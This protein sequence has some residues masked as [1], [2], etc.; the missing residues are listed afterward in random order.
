MKRPSLLYRSAILCCLLSILCSCAPTDTTTSPPEDEVEY[1]FYPEIDGDWWQIAGNPDLGEY[2]TE[3]QQ[4]VDF[5][6]WQAA[7]GTWQLWSCIRHTNCGGN[8]RLFHGWEG[9]SLTDPDWKPL[10]IMME[11]D[12]TLGERQGGMQA[13]HVIVK[14]SIYHMIY[15]SWDNLCL[16][17]SVDGKNF[18]KVIQDHGGTA[19]FRGPMENTRDAMT[20]QI[21]DLYYTYY[22]GHN[23][24]SSNAN[25]KAAIF[26]RTSPDLMEWSE[27]VL[28][29]GGGSVADFDTWGGGDA[30]CPFVVQLEDQYL[31]FRNQ[32]YGQN[33]I[34]TQYLSGNPLDFGVNNDDKVVGMLEVAAP[35]I[36]LHDGQYYI[37]ALLPG[38]NGIRMAKL[39]F[40]KVPKDQDNQERLAGIFGDIPAWNLLGPFSNED[41]KGYETAFPPEFDIDLEAYYPGLFYQQI[42]WQKYEPE[43]HS[44]IDLEQE[45]PGIKDGVAYAQV[46]VWSPDD[47]TT[48]LLFADDDAVK[49]WLNKELVH[50]HN[51]PK[52]QYPRADYCEVQLR[53]GWNDL[54]IKM[55]DSKMSWRYYFRFQDPAGELKYDL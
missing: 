43:F 54:L 46:R 7:D 33:Q 41:G 45:F 37:A 20:I 25:M 18:R 47:R 55:S 53:S 26:C 13:P 35:E 31:L 11:G 5:G 38:L 28:V 19:M 51:V 24:D 21:G 17:T 49:V 10:G 50:Y 34:N 29:S 12:T 16:A 30:E 40:V 9:Q 52:G 22:V 39:K 32:I 6:V 15:G 27:P 3:R 2:T 23:R 4:P 36:I 1:V 8:T 44:L 48:R 42:S 14:D